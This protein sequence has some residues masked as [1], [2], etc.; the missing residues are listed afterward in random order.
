LPP[1][2]QPDPDWFASP[3]IDQGH[4]VTRQEISWGP[5]FGGSEASLKLDRNVNVLPNATPQFDTFNRFVW[6]Q[7]ERWLLSEH[8]PR[9][10]RVTMLTGPVF[11]A[12]EP[13]VDGAPMPRQFWKMALS[14]RPDGTHGLI[15]DAFVI[16]QFREGSDEKIGRT[17]FNTARFRVT[18]QELEQLTGLDFGAEMRTAETSEAVAVAPRPTRPDK[19]VY[20]QFAGMTREEAV[21][22]SDQLKERGWQIPGEERTSLAAGQNEVRYGA[23]ADKPA[24]E[25]LVEDLK[26][27]AL[28]GCC[29]VK[30]NP[31][32]A[33]GTVEVW[34]SR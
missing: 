19:T 16:P 21:R 30:R 13:V 5:E 34:V 12:S 4:L 15:V 17:V 9:A 23:E 22:I 6:S 8:N 26:A 20:F 2:D 33:A 28:K 1:N 32:V 18:V 24:A 10:A 7:L 3:Q 25:M 29:V 31:E 27:L 14:R 11:S